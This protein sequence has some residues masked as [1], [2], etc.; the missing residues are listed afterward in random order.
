MFDPQ[1]RL[2]G[3]V[4]PA[5]PQGVTIRPA[6][7]A[8]CES[9]APRLREEDKAEALAASGVPAEYSLKLALGP[10]TF[11]VLLDGIPEM[12]FGCHDGRPWMLSSP[13]PMS[14]KWRR[15]FLRLTREA[16]DLWNSH[17]QLLH[18]V[19]DARNDTHIRWLKWLGFVF[20]ARH[21]RWGPKGLPFFEFARINPNV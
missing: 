14:P 5:L 16:V 15:T 1:L 10:E 4:H 6:T 19:I 12:M 20:F 13:V 18:N 9:L 21:E 3:R 8:D 11:T 7:P 2:G 17:F